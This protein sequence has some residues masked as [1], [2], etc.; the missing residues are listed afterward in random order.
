MLQRD[1]YCICQFGTDSLSSAVCCVSKGAKHKH[2]DPFPPIGPTTVQTAAQLWEGILKR[3][4]LRSEADG[5][6]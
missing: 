6:C 1:F 3:K 4:E 2:S 5:C